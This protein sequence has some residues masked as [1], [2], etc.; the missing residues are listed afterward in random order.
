MGDGGGQLLADVSFIHQRIMK[1]NTMEMR[2]IQSH[3]HEGAL[4]DPGP[5][6][7]DLTSLHEQ[8]QGFLNAAERA[9]EG[10]MSHDSQAFLEAIPQH[11]AQ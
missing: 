8:A 2:E 5:A 9:L 11:S 4:G 1:G 7:P 6:M 3:G 10:T